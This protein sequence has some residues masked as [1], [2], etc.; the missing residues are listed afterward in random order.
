MN[1]SRWLS[2]FAFLLFASLA[3][4]ADF[5]TKPLRLVVP[6]PPG[7]LLDNLGRALSPGLAAQLGQ[8]VVIENRP[9]ELAAEMQSDLARLGRIV[10]EAGIRAD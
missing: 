3:G 1:S 4:A 9:G 6:Y 10:K 8:P 5:P 7:G 2:L